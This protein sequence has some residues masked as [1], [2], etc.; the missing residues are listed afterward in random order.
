VEL[1]NV[2][3]GD[4][5]WSLVVFFFMVVYFIILFQVI[6]D[7]FRRDSSGWNKAIWILFIL[8]APFLSLFI[9]LVVNGNNMSKRQMSDMAEAQQ[10][11]ADY[12]RDVAGSGGGAAEEI[13]RAKALLDSGAITQ[14][15]FNR[16]KAKALG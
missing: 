16:L 7:L 8:V 3:L 9:Y 2:S 4:L 10:R 15:E 14:E 1:L 12:I 6:G 5:L 13:A 11:Q